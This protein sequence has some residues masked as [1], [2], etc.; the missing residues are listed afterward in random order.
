MYHSNVVM[1]LCLLLLRALQ[2]LLNGEA[3]YLTTAYFLLAEGKAEVIKRM[4]GLSAAQRY[5]SR[6][7]P[8]S[9]NH[10]SSHHTGE[11][12]P[13]NHNPAPLSCNPGGL[14]G[15]SSNGDH[16]KHGL[17][18]HVTTPAD[19]LMNTGIQPRQSIPVG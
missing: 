4:R 10:G 5:I 12:S 11:S 15:R 13:T 19:K 8:P 3:N 17:T 2:Y 7:A 1:T 14:G 9:H 6:A 16:G 18:S